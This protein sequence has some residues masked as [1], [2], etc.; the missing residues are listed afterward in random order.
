MSKYQYLIERK[1]NYQINYDVVKRNIDSNTAIYYLSS[2]VDS[3]IVNDL[4]KGFMIKRNTYLNGSVIKENNIDN[5][6][7]AIFS[8]CLLLVDDDSYYIVETRN[9][10]TRGINESETEKSLKGSHESFNESIITNTGLLRRRIKDTKYKC[11]LFV[12]GNE[13]KTD[14]SINYLEG[15]VDKKILIKITIMTK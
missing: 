11:E 5:M 10:P 15:K 9:Y 12:V 2:L 14:I 13:S 6:V 1:I 4:I 3:Y 8:G 7:T